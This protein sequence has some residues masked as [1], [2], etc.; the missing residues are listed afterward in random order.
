[1]VVAFSFHTYTRAGASSVFD[2]GL[3]LAK[4]EL[5]RKGGRTSRL[6]IR[7]SAVGALAAIS[8]AGTV[9]VSSSVVAVIIILYIYSGVSL[10]KHQKCCVAKESGIM[11]GDGANTSTLLRDIP[12]FEP[13]KFPGFS[14]VGRRLNAKKKGPICSV[15]SFF[16]IRV[17][18]GE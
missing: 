2:G 1:M 4:R 8:W 14:G 15:A 7:L 12:A 11:V 16:F 10:T 3:C 9:V 13:R 5:E 6:S 17:C 18:C